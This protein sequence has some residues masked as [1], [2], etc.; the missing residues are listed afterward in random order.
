[1]P[2]AL[3][4]SI[5]WMWP[6]TSLATAANVALTLSHSHQRRVLLIDADLRRP[7]C[8]RYL[9][10]NAEA[11][12]ADVLLG[13]VPVERVLRPAGYRNLMLLGAGLAFYLGK[14]LIQP[15]APQVPALALGGWSDSPAV[16]S[17]LAINALFPGHLMAANALQKDIEARHGPSD[18]P[19]WG[20]RKPSKGRK[21]RR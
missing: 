21:G 9:N 12:V 6:G 11:G 20:G 2:S 5:C 4:V 19:G 17:A 3:Y 10:L 1:M 15:Q 16:Q 18:L 13:R 14:P 8:E 7:S